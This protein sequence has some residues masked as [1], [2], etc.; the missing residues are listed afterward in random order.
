[1]YVV[2]FIFRTKSWTQRVTTSILPIPQYANEILVLF[3]IFLLMFSLGSYPVKDCLYDPT[4]IFG[5]PYTP[6]G[7]PYLGS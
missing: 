4:G 5:P 6:R 2:Q 1:M 7:T 3:R